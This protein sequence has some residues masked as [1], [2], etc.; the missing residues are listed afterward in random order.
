[1]TDRKENSMGFS[2]AEKDAFSEVIASM[3]EQIPELVERFLGGAT[4]SELVSDMKKQAESKQ[5]IFPIKPTFWAIAFTDALGHL[6][7]GAEEN[8]AKIVAEAREKGV[9]PGRESINGSIRIQA[10]SCVWQMVDEKNK[11]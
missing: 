9:V 6:E 11:L 1:M 8:L 3:G 5:R 4:I 10:L 2:Q 7:Q